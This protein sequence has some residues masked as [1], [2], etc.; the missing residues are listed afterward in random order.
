[1]TSCELFAAA[2]GS[3]GTRGTHRF[4]CPQ[5]N[6]TPLFCAAQ[7][8]KEEIVRVLLARRGVDVTWRDRKGRL[9]V[10]ITRNREIV[11][12]IQEYEVEALSKGL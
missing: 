9:A 6:R 12:L 4:V 10:D 1:L 2:K 8:G 7:S 11:S 3:I 5:P